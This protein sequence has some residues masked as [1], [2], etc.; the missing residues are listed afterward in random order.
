MREQALAR[1]PG[2][3]REL[4]RGGLAR[5]LYDEDRVSEAAA[6][7][8]EERPPV[9]PEPVEPSRTTHISVVDAEGNAASLTA[10]T[11]AGL[12]RGRA[13]ARGST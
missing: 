9:I 2:F 13:R 11:G 10:S 5:R 7:L 3:A 8:M 1:G 6:R 4:H 12:G